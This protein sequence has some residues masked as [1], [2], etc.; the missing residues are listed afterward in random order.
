V[1]LSGYGTKDFGIFEDER[2]LGTI[3]K[4]ASIE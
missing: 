3:P 1:L 4:I 2:F